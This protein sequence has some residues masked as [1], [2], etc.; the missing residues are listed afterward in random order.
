MR[1]CAQCAI[2][3]NHIIFAY[4]PDETRP[5][6]RCAQPCECVCA[7]VCKKTRPS[8]RSISIKMCEMFSFSVY[9]Y[10]F[11]VYRGRARAHGFHMPYFYFSYSNLFSLCPSFNSFLNGLWFI[12]CD[13]HSS[14]FSFLLVSFRCLLFRFCT[15]YACF[16]SFFHAGDL[17]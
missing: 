13:I 14:F 10:T 9:H 15:A 12:V 4:M 8:R 16:H 2:A 3:F 11:S 5:D 1:A 6:H 7:N 17:K